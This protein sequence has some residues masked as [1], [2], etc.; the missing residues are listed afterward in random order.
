MRWVLKENENIFM[1]HILRSL[2]PW[3]IRQRI[4]SDLDL[5]YH[6]LKMDF[7]AIIAHALPIEWVFERMDIGPRLDKK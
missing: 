1:S 7:S 3:S 5:P 2:R 6:N 4:E